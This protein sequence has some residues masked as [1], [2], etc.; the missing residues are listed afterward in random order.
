[1]NLV[2]EDK[3]STSGMMC[4]PLKEA[5]VRFIGTPHFVQSPNFR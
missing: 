5:V 4:H 2:L 3:I 1:L